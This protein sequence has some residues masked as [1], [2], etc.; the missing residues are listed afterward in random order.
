MIFG[1]FLALP[2]HTSYM[3]PLMG[4]IE[5]VITRNYFRLILFSELDKWLC[6]TVFLN[7]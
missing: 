6:V 3:V 1:E 4:S 5:I 7:F 2:D